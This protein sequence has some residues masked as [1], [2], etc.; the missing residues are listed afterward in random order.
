[1]SYLIFCSFEVGGLPYHF[2][3]LLNKNGIQTYYVSVD[4]PSNRHDSTA[5]HYGQCKAADWDLSPLFK[6]DLDNMDVMIGRLRDLKCQ[7]DIKGCFATGSKAF[8][9]ARAGIPYAYWSFGADLDYLYSPYFFPQVRSFLKKYYYR[10]FRKTSFSEEMFK[11]IEAAKKLMISPYQKHM[12]DRF[13]ISKQLFFIPHVYSTAGD[14][15]AVIKQKEDCRKALC[16]RFGADYFFFSS[17][18]QVWKNRSSLTGDNKNNDIAIKAFSLY[19]QKTQGDNCKLVMINKGCD[20]DATKKMIG[21]LSLR[22][23][24]IW[25]DE[26]KRQDLFK[27][28]MGSELCLGHFGTPVVTNAALEPLS[29]AT[30]C[31]SYYGQ[32]AEGM[33]FYDEYPPLYN[34]NDPARIADFM[35][36]VNKDK[37]L[38]GQLRYKSW[39]WIRRFCSEKE[40]TGRFISIFN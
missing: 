27:Y 3:E 23:H 34:S 25:I 8:L 35:V 9:L 38:A 7:L 32:E 10:L 1:M 33:P 31:I 26:I 14:F 40:F 37:E 21:S 15:D 24:V 13:G 18:R 12:L 16:S 28:Y 22:E 11:T 2:A 20:V 17:V 29:C 19:L 30:P 6:E 4:R 39:D 5:F 36:R